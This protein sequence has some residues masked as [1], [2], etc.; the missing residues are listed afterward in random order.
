MLRVQA[1]S[2]LYGAEANLRS[3]LWCGCNYQVTGLVGYR[4]LNLSDQLSIT[5][6]TLILRD[7]PFNPPDV[8]VNA[9]TQVTVFDRFD[10]HNQFYGG[11]VDAAAVE[12]QRDRWT[13]EA[14]AKLALGVTEQ[15]VDIAGSQRF[16]VA[17]NGTTQ[18]F[19]GGLYA[20]PSNIGHHSQY[21][22]AV[23]PDVGFK[24]GY[25]LTSNI[26]IFVGYDFLY[27][28]SVL[29]PGDQIDQVL[30]LNQV[31]QS[32]RPYPA[33]NQVRP[34]VPFRTTSYFA[35]GVNAGIEIRY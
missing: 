1:S 4:Y 14:R 26:R 22:F 32:G 21:R 30:D 35:T 19:N 9:G 34:V 8:P 23:V 20:L 2:S 28:S 24:L 13:L 3:L 16:L 27:W 33:A 7:I 25:D 12:W 5:E 18:T 11:Q 15:A 17:P 10:T 29:R 6:N 31:P